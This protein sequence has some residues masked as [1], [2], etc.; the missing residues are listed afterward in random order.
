MPEGSKGLRTTLMGAR[1]RGSPAKIA[2]LLAAVLRT[3]CICTTGCWSVS[4]LAESDASEPLTTAIAALPLA[5]ALEAFARETG[6]NVVYVSGVVRDQRSPAV[7]A[8]LN[9][10]QALTRLLE[11]TGLRFEFFTARSIRILADDQPIGPWQPTSL[12]DRYR[13]W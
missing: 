11:G 8:G 7:P 4:A 3:V 2:T 13:R 5:Q 12:S 1:L 10:R 6:L 9:A